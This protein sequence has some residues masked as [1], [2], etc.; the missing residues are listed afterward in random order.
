MLNL[1]IEI[2]MMTSMDYKH[3]ILSYKAVY[4]MISLNKMML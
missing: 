4:S 3:I 1:M 2:S